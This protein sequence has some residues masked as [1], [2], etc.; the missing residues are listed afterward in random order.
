MLV[1]Q[2]Q[3]GSLPQLD[4]CAA[5]SRGVFRLETVAEFLRRQPLVDGS[6]ES[7]CPNAMDNKD[8]GQGCVTHDQ[9]INGIES[10][11]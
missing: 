2:I 11:F 10:S 4:N 9:L 6:S 5:A 8:R 3:I 7:A 1:I